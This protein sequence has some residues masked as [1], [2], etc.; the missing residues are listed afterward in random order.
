MKYQGR[1][2]TIDLLKVVFAFAV[3]GIH[4]SLFADSNP[5]L[6][7]VL[8]MGL[9]RLG[10]P[11]Y[12][13]VSGFYFASRL[14]GRKKS[15][16]WLMKLVRIYVV[17]ELIDLILNLVINPGL[18]SDPVG[19]VRRVCTAGMNGIYWYLVSLF[20]TCFLLRPLWRRGYEKQLIVVG[21]LLY[22]AAMTVDSY[23]FL[24]S[25][26]WLQGLMKMHM[27]FWRWP[28]AG[29][30]ESV[31]F[32]SLGVYMRK[33]SLPDCS[34][35]LLPLFLILLV[36]EAMFTQVHGAA[37]AN[38]YL[39]LPLCTVFLLQYCLKHPD[40]KFHMPLFSDL[41]LY[42]Y[43]VHP[44]INYV[45]WA[46]GNSVFRFAASSLLSMLLS[47]LIIRAKEKVRKTGNRTI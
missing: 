43:M 5:F 14:D 20:L 21:A 23:S 13:M 42:V 30:T 34:A 32:L 35:F 27:S 8:T 46:L 12:F 15:N 7:H 38:C 3:I 47:V 9:F 17:F 41:S 22:L 44:Y 29:L 31:L 45:T 24:P 2:R 25:P 36:T 28:Q 26:A 1:N 33:N 37:D 10:V 11:F 18:L 4:L 6:N 39:S 19:I 16:A 40:V